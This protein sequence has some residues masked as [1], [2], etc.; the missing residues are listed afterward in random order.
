MS[1]G[2]C[3]LASV[4]D[5][6]GALR[7]KR[8]SAY[9]S[10]CPCGKTVRRACARPFRIQARRCRGARTASR[11][12]ARD[13]LW[14]ECIRCCPSM[15]AL[16]LDIGMNDV[17]WLLPLARLMT[18]REHPLLKASTNA[19]LSLALSSGGLAMIVGLW[20]PA[21]R[22]LRQFCGA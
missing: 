18:L 14:R 13:S 22:D 17:F 6:R 16:M 10:N 2:E 5:V 7:R 12:D 8:D 15:I 1:V 3:R 4:A 9:L 21:M 19:A 11:T 20:V